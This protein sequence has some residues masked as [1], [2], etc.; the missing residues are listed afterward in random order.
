V[1][2]GE[3]CSYYGCWQEGALLSSLDAIG[4]LHVRAQAA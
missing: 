4:R 3:H 1:L 2:A